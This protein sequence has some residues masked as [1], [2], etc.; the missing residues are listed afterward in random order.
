MIGRF[1]MGLALVGLAGALAGCGGGAVE[2]AD[3][4]SPES[5][6]PAM[7][8][9]SFPGGPTT[10]DDPPIPRTAQPTASAK[11]DLR[12]R[13]TVAPTP[14]PGAE[15]SEPEPPSPDPSPAEEYPSTGRSCED[16]LERVDGLGGL[17]VDCETA[18]RVAAAYDSAI[19]GAGDFPD[20]A[21]LAVADAW[22]CT[23]TVAEESEESFSVLC[24]RGDPRK[25]AVSFSWGV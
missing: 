5:S 18:G 17:G 8:S 9:N 25:E 16:D 19:M 24:D 4:G 14:E 11:P 20:G 6:P 22:S 3:S 7:D 21:V 23:S 2:V 10:A 13:R 1:K 12:A 15:A